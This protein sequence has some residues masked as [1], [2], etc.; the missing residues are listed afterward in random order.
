MRPLTRQD[1]IDPLV[2]KVQKCGAPGCGPKSIQVLMQVK[3]YIKQEFP[4]WV[5]SSGHCSDYD[6]IPNLRKPED[7]PQAW[8]QANVRQLMNYVEPMKCDA[9]AE[10]GR[11][12]L[13]PASEWGQEGHLWVL[14]QGPLKLCQPQ[15]ASPEKKRAEQHIFAEK[16]I[17]TLDCTAR[18]VCS[19]HAA[20]SF[21]Y[22]QD[23]PRESILTQ[24]FLGHQTHR[25]ETADAES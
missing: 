22:S 9:H 24:L 14:D 20:G 8:L 5:C 11:H 2:I 10:M 7:D 18:W 21:T 19:C 6:E 4:V 16:E 12:D 17:N 13:P 1:H 3:G 15:A 23:E 25:L